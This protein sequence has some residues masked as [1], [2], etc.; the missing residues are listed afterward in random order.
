M[1]KEFLGYTILNDNYNCN[2]I[3]KCYEYYNIIKDKIRGIRK[4]FYT[5]KLFL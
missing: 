1:S 5:I 2:H 4:L 3:Y